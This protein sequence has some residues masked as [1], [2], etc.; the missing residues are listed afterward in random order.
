MEVPRVLDGGKHSQFPTGIDGDIDG[1]KKLSASHFE[2]E[3]SAK[4]V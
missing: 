2:C 4:R 3:K 1:G